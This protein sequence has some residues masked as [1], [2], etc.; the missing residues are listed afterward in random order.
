MFFFNYSKVPNVLVWYIFK[1]LYFFK[2]FGFDKLKLSIFLSAEKLKY[3]FYFRAV[4]REY[5]KFI[6]AQFRLALKDGWLL[7]QR[8][9]L[10]KISDYHISW[11]EYWI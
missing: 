8:N 7:Q 2:D 10:N 6:I 3:V 9:L 11:L 1:K 4:I 5:G